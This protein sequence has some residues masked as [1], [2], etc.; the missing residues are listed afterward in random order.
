MPF[1]FGVVREVPVEKIVVE[2][3]ETVVEVDKIVEKIVRVPLI[4][5]KTL[6]GVLREDVAAGNS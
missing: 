4:I 6:P 3:V 2:Q 5:T 1:L